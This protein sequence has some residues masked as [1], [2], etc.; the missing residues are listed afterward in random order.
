MNEI[1]M[2]STRTFTPEKCEARNPTLG[3]GMGLV[4]ASGAGQEPGSGH[5]TATLLA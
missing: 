5:S 2:L 3:A 4:R 1:C